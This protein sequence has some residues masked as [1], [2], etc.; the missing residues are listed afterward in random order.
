MERRDHRSFYKVP[1]IGEYPEIELEANSR[2]NTELLVNPRELELII[3][4]LKALRGEVMIRD[5]VSGHGAGDYHYP[6][7]HNW[8]DPKET[9]RV[10]LGNELDSFI[11]NI[12]KENIVEHHPEV[13]QPTKGA[14][15]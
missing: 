8:V 13:I 15:A 1:G 5:Q 14:E 6:P 3:R 11:D 9:G 7:G 10:P 2:R 12:I 4:G